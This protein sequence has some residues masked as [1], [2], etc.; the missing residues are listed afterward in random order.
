MK[1]L[2][3]LIVC[4]L[5]TVLAAAAPKAELWNRW[6]PFDPSS[7]ETVDHGEWQRFLDEY[8]DFDET[9]RT[10]VDY[11]RVSDADT[12][13]LIQHVDDLEAVQ[14]LSLNRDEQMAYWINLYNARTVQLILENPGKK[15]I[16]NIRF[17][18]TDFGPWDEPLLEVEGEP[19]TLNDI[20]HRILRPIWKDPRIH[21][22]VNCA[23][24]GCPNLAPAAY[25]AATLEELLEDEARSYINH[26]RGV[27][28]SQKRFLLSSI[29]DWYQDDFSGNTEGVVNH[30]VRYAEPALREALE[31][32]TGRFSYD[33]DWDLNQR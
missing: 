3:W 13:S 5:S 9:G 33:Y 24:M 15:S 21:Y 4:L 14:V 29:Y 19:L 31:N 12:Q 16:R 7:A 20:E 8:L 6:E 1:T 27:D 18:I 32:Y 25:T 26:P 11:T 10:R 2:T 28:I 30:L 22:A 17:K 23:S